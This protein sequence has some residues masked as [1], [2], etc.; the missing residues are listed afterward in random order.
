MDKLN[1]PSVKLFE[2]LNVTG[3]P[4]ALHVRVFL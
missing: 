1:R 2:V 4:Q 3:L